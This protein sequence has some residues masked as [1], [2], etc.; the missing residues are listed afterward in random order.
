MSNES[1]TKLPD[2]KSEYKPLFDAIRKVVPPSMK[3]YLVG[4]AV[5]DILLNRKIRDFDFTVEGLV[6][7]IGKHIADELNGAYYVLDDERDMVRV[8]IDDE[9]IGQFDIDIALLTGSDIEEDLRERDFTFNAMAI[10]ISDEPRLI[11]PLNGWEAILS[12]R[13]HMCDENSLS[14]DPLRA[15][16]AV[17]MNLEFGLEPDEQLLDAMRK[18]PSQMSESSFER[19]RDELFKIIRL[20]Q[21]SKAVKIFND[22]HYLDHLFPDW[23]GD[24]D[25]VNF[26][27][28]ENVDLFSK[29]LTTRDDSENID[30]AFL[31]FA[32]ARLGNYRES[33][34]AFF[35]KTLALYHTRRMLLAFSAIAYALS[36]SVIENIKDWCRQLTFSSSETN[37]AILSLQAFDYLKE[38]QQITRFGDVDIYR[39]FKKFKEGGISGLILYLAE[40]YCYRN[41]PDAYKNWCLKVVFV[42]NL[43]SAYFSRYMEVIEPRPLLTGRDIQNILEK[44]AGPLIGQMKNALIE[45]QIEGSVKTI[46]EA[47]AYIRM[48]ENNFINS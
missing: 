17:R 32:E 46:Q 4:G 25:K 11:D 26:P 34:S 41:S 29:K 31:N 9:E 38:A 1:L 16:R 15:L 47:E 23:C 20:N 36:A 14:A 10:E 27:W 42:Q 19:Y 13:L 33:L 45:A 48:H 30:D 22:F 6:R 24:K 7:P 3:I 28:I 21:N 35:D 37:F 43:I 39:F 5:R 40:N 12:K 8:I 18:V 44:Q 2:F